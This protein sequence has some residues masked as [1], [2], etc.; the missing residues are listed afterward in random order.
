MGQREFKNCLRYGLERKQGVAGSGLWGGGDVVVCCA[1][2]HV[3]HH[4][5][6]PAVF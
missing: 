3:A 5:L 6:F 2:D 4:V 1:L